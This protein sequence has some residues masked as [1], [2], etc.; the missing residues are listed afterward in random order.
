MRGSPTKLLPRLGGGYR[1]CRPCSGE[2]WIEGAI[3]GPFS[4]GAEAVP[5]AAQGP[6]LLAASRIGAAELVKDR[7]TE[8]ID[9]ALLDRSWSI[10][11][12]KLAREQQTPMARKY[13]APSSGAADGSKPG[14][15]PQRCIAIATARPE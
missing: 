14:V 7:Q 9:D 13:D 12:S 8:T 3:A 6:A 1:G 2:R 10:C 15:A 11:H 4:W 5:S